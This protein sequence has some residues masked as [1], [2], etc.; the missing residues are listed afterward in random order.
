M[1]HLFELKRGLMGAQE[2]GVLPSELTKSLDKVSFVL[3]QVDAS[4]GKENVMLGVS[5]IYQEK[6]EE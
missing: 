3:G 5:K 4:G 2:R 6:L 1:Y